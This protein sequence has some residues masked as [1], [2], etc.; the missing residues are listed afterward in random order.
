MKFIL[1]RKEGM[2]QIFTAEGEMIPATVVVAG[3]CYI[4]QVKTEETDGYAAVQLG[5]KEKK[6]QRTTKSLK[7]HFKKMLQAVEQGGEE[8]KK[9]EFQALHYLKEF[10]IPDVSEFSLGDEIS[11]NNFA[12]GDVVDVIGT[13][14][15]RGFTGVMKRW[16]FHGGP[17]SHGAMCDRRPGAI[18]MHSDPSR[19][20]KGKKMAGHY[21][22]ERLTVKNLEVLGV[23]PERNVLLI[24]GAVPGARNGLLSI[25]TAKTAKPK[26]KPQTEVKAKKRK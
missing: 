6:P 11:V 5:F 16:N 12:E 9:H 3:P 14:K 22:C 26:K 24:K 13:S 21:G 18:G 2:T 25:Q 23:L 17:K 15:G 10:R 20:F 4:C 8:S 19:V 1:G 7:G